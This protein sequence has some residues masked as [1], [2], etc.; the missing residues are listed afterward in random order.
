MMMMMMVVVV[1][2]GVVVEEVEGG[3]ETPTINMMGD[4]MIIISTRYS[5]SLRYYVL[6]I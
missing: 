1:V 3:C 5:S 6:I 2:V 4:Y